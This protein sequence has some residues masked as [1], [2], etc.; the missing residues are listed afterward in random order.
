[1]VPMLREMELSAGFRRLATQRNIALPSGAQ[2]LLR[3]LGINPG[4][5][6]RG[7]HPHP[8]PLPLGAGSTGAASRVAFR[9]R[10]VTLSEA[11]LTSPRGVQGIVDGSGNLAPRAVECGPPKD[12]SSG[13]MLDSAPVSR[14]MRLRAGGGVSGGLSGDHRSQMRHYEHGRVTNG[15]GAVSGGSG[16]SRDNFSRGSFDSD[17]SPD[18]TTGGRGSLGS[19]STASAGGRGDFG[20]RAGLGGTGNGVGNPLARHVV[21]FVTSNVISAAAVDAAIRTVK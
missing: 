20:T 19:F 16:A 10:A 17:F 21:V 2:F 5:S 7:P 6:G 4:S 18:S 14:V 13:T 1:M 8:P 3:P 11:G 12:G 9:A 15:L